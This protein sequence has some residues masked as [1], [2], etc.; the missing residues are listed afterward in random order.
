MRWLGSAHNPL[1]RSADRAEAA[2]LVILSVLFL[3]AVPL[4]IWAGA[5]TYQGAHRDAAVDA[6]TRHRVVGVLVADAPGPYAVMGVAMPT[7]AIARWPAP[8]G[9]DRT[10][11]TGGTARTGYVWAVAGSPAGTRVTVWTDGTGLRVNPPAT[12]AS[13]VAKGVGVGVL[14]V[15][16]AG[17]VLAGS[18]LLLRY[19]LDRGRLAAWDAEWA[20][21]AP[22]WR[23]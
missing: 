19:F 20:R 2:A 8:N 5:R 9:I 18:H 6:A 3:I 4:A 12:E 7:L 22:Q 21:V 11:S 1:C 16:T 13:A 17:T 23:R 10:D 14:A 15:G